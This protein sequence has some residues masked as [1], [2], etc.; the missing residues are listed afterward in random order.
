MITKRGTYVEGGGHF[1]HGVSPSISRAFPC[2][3]HDCI[4]GLSVP[5]PWLR[6]SDRP[7]RRGASVQHFRRKVPCDRAPRHRR[8]PRVPRNGRRSMHALRNFWRGLSAVDV[9]ERRAVPAGGGRLP[10]QLRG[11]AAPPP[12][13]LVASVVGRGLPVLFSPRTLCQLWPIMRTAMRTVQAPFATSAAATSA[14]SL[15]PHWQAHGR[16]LM[17][18]LCLPSTWSPCASCSTALAPLS[19]TISSS[20]S[21]SALPEPPFTPSRLRAFAYRRCIR[22]AASEQSDPTHASNA[23]HLPAMAHRLRGGE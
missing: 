9:R 11:W 3:Y 14:G 6:R 1:E 15:R 22:A 23:T 10:R 16:R 17:Q 4:S 20:G 13:A 5:A 8:L 12:I 7:R 18:H 19:S 21:S 2:P